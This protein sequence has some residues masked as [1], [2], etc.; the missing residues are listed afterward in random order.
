MGVS[1]V[2]YIRVLHQFGLITD[3]QHRS[4]IIEAS[5]AGYRRQEGDIDRES[6]QLLPKIL[7]MLREDGVSL[8]DLAQEL[9]LNTDDL[10]GLLLS[11]FSVVGGGNLPTTPRQRTHLRVV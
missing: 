9:G 10:R 4:L 7:G 2:A 5:S 11:S 6:S 8:P 1:A 3:W